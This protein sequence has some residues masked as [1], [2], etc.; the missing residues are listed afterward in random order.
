L[1]KGFLL[2][3]IIL[4]FAL[5]GLI[6][7]TIQPALAMSVKNLSTLEDKSVG[8]DHCKRITEIL[9]CSNEV[10]DSF[11]LDLINEGEPTEYNDSMLT[12]AKILCT[13]EV[14]GRDDLIINYRVTTMSLD[15]EVTYASFTC[16]RIL[17]EEE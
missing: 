7:V 8:I 13:V 14:I 5:I 12:E 17:M 1:R 6:V 9:R 10:N 16:A 4:G 3:D 11:F 2:I 15:K